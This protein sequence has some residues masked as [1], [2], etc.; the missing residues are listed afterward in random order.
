[1]LLAA[2][3]T[4]KQNQ[5]SGRFFMRS[6]MKF[7]KSLT[8]L[9]VCSNEDYKSPRE[10]HEAHL[11]QFQHFDEN[12]FIETRRTEGIEDDAAAMTSDPEQRHLTF[13]RPH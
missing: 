5:S 2:D 9:D 13:C 11:R 7:L 3:E 10:P 4:Q 12:L 8:Q 6:I 1:E